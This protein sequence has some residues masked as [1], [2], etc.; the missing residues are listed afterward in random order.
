[1]KEYSSMTPAADSLAYTPDGKGLAMSRGRSIVLHSLETGQ[2]VVLPT[3]DAIWS[4]AI[5]SDGR[6]LVAGL[7]NKVAILVDLPE[8]RLASTFKGHSAKVVTV[9]FSPD[10]TLVGTGSSDG[11]AKVWDVQPVPDRCVLA[12]HSRAV[13]SLAFSADGRLLASAGGDA[14]AKLWDLPTQRAIQTWTA[15]NGLARAVAFSGDGSRL[16]VVLGETAMVWD[17]NQAREL[18]RV[19]G[20]ERQLRSVAL[21][22]DGRHLVTVCWERQADLWSVETGEKLWTLG[23][24]RTETWS[25]AYRPLAN[26]V[27][28]GGRLP[29]IG[30]WNPEARQLIR[31]VAGHQRTVNFVTYSPRGDVFASAGWDGFVNILDAAQAKPISSIKGFPWAA[32]TVA[33]SPDSRRLA[34]A[35][36]DSHIK[37][38]RVWEVSTG[39]DLLS[40]PGATAPKSVSFSPDGKTLASGGEDG[41]ITLWLTQPR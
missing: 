33:F 25:A 26:E 2:E 12:G 28:T 3:E 15:T 7:E 24:A 30:F 11:L 32:L 5:S 23:D 29:T 14:L 1:V 8:M 41:S 10:G 38:L 19:S 39:F 37:E 13:W 36:G 6:R 27:A 22:H 34:S 16:V 18:R 17:V 35:A 21:S 4:I 40:L 9:A 20:C 31:S